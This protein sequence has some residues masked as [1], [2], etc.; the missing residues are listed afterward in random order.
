MFQI[1]AKCIWPSN[2]L[3]S[4]LYFQSCATHCL[5]LLLKDW[6]GGGGGTWVKQIVKRVKTIVS[7]IQ[8]HHTPFVTFCR[9]E[10]NLMLEN[11]TE[12]QFHLVFCKMVVD[13]ETNCWTNYH[14][15]WMDDFCQHLSH[16]STKVLHQGKICL[17]QHKEGWALEYLWQLC[18]NGGT[19]FY[20]VEGIWWQTTLYGEGVACHEY[21]VQQQVL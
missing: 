8:Q 5:D 3:F 12:T 15:P 11:L 17:N 9:Y 18:G 10:T 4:S 21:I 20:V 14:S 2:P 13:N 6:K 19:D 1:C 16:P 7:F